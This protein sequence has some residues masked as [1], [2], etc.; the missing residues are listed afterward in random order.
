MGAGET[1]I[2]E[3]SK[4]LS[5]KYLCLNSIAPYFAMFP[6][7]FPL[8][9]LSCD[10]R[11]RLTKS[12]PTWVL[13]PFCGR[14]TT[15]FAARVLGYPSVG[16]DISP[17]A[18]AIASAKLASSTEDEI[19]RS[20]ERLIA[21]Y[22]AEAHVPEGEFWE[23]AYHPKTL[24]EICAIRQ[25]LLESSTDLKPS[26][27]GADDM[28]LLRAIMLGALHGPRGKV[29]QNYLSNQMPRTYATKPAAAVRF[30]KK[31]NLTP[32]YVDTL[33]VIRRRARRVTQSLP[34]RTGGFVFQSDARSVRLK[35]FERSFGFIITSPPYYRMSTYITDQWLRYWF[36]GGPPAPDYSLNKQLDMSSP[37][38]YA[39]ELSRVWLNV[40]SYAAPG[41]VL[42]V[43]LG[44]IPSAAV[45]ASAIAV[46]SITST[47]GAWRI[48]KVENAENPS[49]TRRQAVQFRIGTSQPIQEIDV[50]AIFEG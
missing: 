24:R 19:V 49:R 11:G 34:P 8:K 1:G 35:G 9:V 12:S 14:G 47:G 40:A 22:A 33:A 29:T 41:C 31:R 15:N 26:S 3:V 28:V 32:P 5:P 17:V 45:D 30:W 10:N 27:G 42:A 23:Y 46:E 18:V 37:D 38:S 4:Y 50:L 6:P 43:R 2:S 25:G 39:R 36:L 20:A 7:S 21:A 16:I 48:L 13:D 44:S